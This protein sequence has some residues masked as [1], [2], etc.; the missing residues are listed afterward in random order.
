MT[1]LSLIPKWILGLTVCLYTAPSQ[2]LRLTFGPDG[3]L[4]AWKKVYR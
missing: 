4:K 2:Y 3:E 1:T